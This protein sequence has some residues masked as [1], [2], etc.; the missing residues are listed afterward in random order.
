MTRPIASFEK[1]REYLTSSY[2]VQIRGMGKTPADIPDNF[3]LLLEGIIDSLGVL[4]MIGGIE[5]EFG[6]TLDMAGLDAEEMTI[7]GPLARFVASQAGAAPQHSVTA[8]TAS[9]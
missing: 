7:L 9:L 8:G 2:E 5:K 1:V 6:L 4:E 3:D